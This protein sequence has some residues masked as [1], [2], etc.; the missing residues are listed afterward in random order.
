MDKDKVMKKKLEAIE[1]RKRKIDE[2]KKRRIDSNNPKNPNFERDKEKLVKSMVLI[3]LIVFII[4]I[5]ILYF[6]WKYLL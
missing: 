2:I 3:K 6:G 4:G 1:E 5:A